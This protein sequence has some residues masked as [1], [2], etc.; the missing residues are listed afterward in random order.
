MKHVLASLVLAPFFFV[1]ATLVAAGH[2]P[3]QE[4]TP[5]PAKAEK[6]KVGDVLKDAKL[7][8]LDGKDAS[9]LALT[10]GKVA[11]INFFGRH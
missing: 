1:G 7:K 2:A 10:K 11:V 4:G 9:L 3:A 8:D 6:Y 5:K